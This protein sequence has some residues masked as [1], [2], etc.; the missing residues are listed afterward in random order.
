MAD[1]D[2]LPEGE[3]AG[4][5]DTPEIDE[6]PPDDTPAPAPPSIED[7]ASRMGWAPKEEW[8]GD[9]DR[10]K[11]ADEFVANTA[12]I[13]AKLGNRL[14][15]MEKQLETMGRT[16]A[17]IAEQTIAQERQRLLE[18]RD[19]AFDTGDKETFVKLDKKLSELTTETPTQDVPPETQAWVEKNGNWF[20]KDTEA[21]N[22]AK[23][24]AE[25]LAGQGLPPAR[26]LAIVEK[27]ARDFYPEHFEKPKA[28]ASPAP[29]NQ[30]GQRGAPKT[31]AK[32]FAQLPAEA[33]SAALDFEKNGRCTKEEYAKIWFEE[34]EA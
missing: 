5:I 14:S 13:N 3:G 32:G 7:V 6:T 10:W 16:S 29:L 27:E 23:S 33:K 1:E 24:R 31:S 4:A 22:W 34:Q 26:Q 8:R 17:R 28:P 21:T 18:Q 25:Q 19:E 12:D 30:P 2:L 15:N 9:P 11:P 20:G